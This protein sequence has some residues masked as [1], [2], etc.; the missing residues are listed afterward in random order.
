MW[1]ATRKTT[2]VPVRSRLDHRRRVDVRQPLSANVGERLENR[3]SLRAQNPLRSP[4]Q[5]GIPR[6]LVSRLAPILLA[7]ALGAAF[8][9]LVVNPGAVVLERQALSVPRETI[10]GTP[11]SESA[12]VGEDEPTIGVPPES[13]TLPKSHPSAGQKRALTR[14]LKQ[15]EE[16]PPEIPTR[17]IDPARREAVLGAIRAGLEGD[18]Q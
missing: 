14:A 6:R 15:L 17:D 12:I 4:I 1:W 16:A 11:E 8:S 3:T 5:S 7:F 18:P 10:R 13:A 2:P 9:W